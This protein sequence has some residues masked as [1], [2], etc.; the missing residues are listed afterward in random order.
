MILVCVAAAVSLQVLWTDC[1]LV[2]YR[3]SDTGQ[4]RKKLVCTTPNWGPGGSSPSVVYHCENYAV[5]YKAPPTRAHQVGTLLAQWT[6]GA[7]TRRTNTEKHKQPL[8]HTRRQHQTTHTAIQRLRAAAY[9]LP[10]F[11]PFLPFLPPCA[12]QA[13]AQRP[14]NSR[15]RRGAGRRRDNG[16]SVQPTPPIRHSCANIS[17]GSVSSSLNSST[18]VFV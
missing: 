10:F 4:R 12:D 11:P 17:G 18:F 14:Y 1:G 8:S 2:D 5:Q 16:Q 3:S 7:T 6:W 9:F 13:T 15:K